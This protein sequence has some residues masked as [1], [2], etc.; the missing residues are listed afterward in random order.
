MGIITSWRSLKVIKCILYSSKSNPHI[1]LNIDKL[2]LGY[3][4]V[5]LLSSKFLLR[6]LTVAS[7]NG[8]VLLTFIKIIPFQNLCFSHIYVQ[9]GVKYDFYGLF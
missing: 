9:E 4:L 1:L 7:A 6:T 8:S 5:I 3:R 2:L